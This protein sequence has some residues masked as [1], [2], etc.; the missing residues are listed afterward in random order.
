[1]TTLRLLSYP[2]VSTTDGRDISRAEERARC[3]EIDSRE[4]RARDMFY[5]SRKRQQ[6]ASRLDTFD[7]DL[8]DLDDP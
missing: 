8:T 3:E 6:D 7:V 1:V 2:A 5:A 4:R